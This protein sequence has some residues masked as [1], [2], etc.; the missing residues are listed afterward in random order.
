M[1]LRWELLIW[2]GLFDWFLELLT[3]WCKKIAEVFWNILGVSD[4]ISF[5]MQKK[6]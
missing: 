3:H 4:S 5:Q 2:K 6:M 1:Y